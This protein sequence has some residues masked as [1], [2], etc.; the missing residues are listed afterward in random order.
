M[1][2]YGRKKKDKGVGDPIRSLLE[3]AL[4]RERDKIMKK[5][6]QILRR[7]LVKADT[8]TSSDNF[9][10]AAPFKVQFNFDISIFEVQIDANALEKWVIF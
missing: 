7:L 3:E 4:A 5:N 10:G 8:S 2:S 1:T 9:G 6:S